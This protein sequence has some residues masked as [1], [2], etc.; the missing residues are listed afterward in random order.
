MKNILQ[1][2]VISIFIL[3]GI[4]IGIWINYPPPAPQNTTVDEF[5]AAAVKEHIQQIAAAPHPIGTAAHAEV[6]DTITNKLA[7]LGLEAEIQNSI[8]IWPPSGNVIRAATVNNIIARLPGSENSRAV[9]LMTHYDSV[10]YAPGANDDSA[11]VAV[12][13]ETMRLITSGQQLNNDIIVLI[14]DGE[15]IGLA[16]AGVFFREHPWAADI[17]VVLNLEARGCSGGVFMFETGPDN[18]WLIKDWKNASKAP[19]G[20]SISNAIYK[21]MPNDTDFSIPKKL[22]LPGLNFAYIDGWF[23]YH[24]PLDNTDHLDLDTLAHYGTNILP[25]VK[26]LGNK[27]LTNLPAGDAVYFQLWPSGMIMYPAAFTWYIIAGI[28][29]LLLITIMVGFHNKRLTAKGLLLGF[30]API[31]YTGVGILLISLL[32]KILRLCL[33][34]SIAEK[35]LYPDYR[36]IFLPAFSLILL[37][38]FFF[39]HRFLSRW[40]NILSLGLGALGW[41]LSGTIALKIL[42]PGG[43]FIFMWPLLFGLLSLWVIFYLDRPESISWSKVFLIGILVLPGLIIF[44]QL[45]F[46]LTLSFRLSSL[47]F[48]IVGIMTGILIPSLAAMSRSAMGRSAAAALVLAAVVFSYGL[49]TQK[50]IV[51]PK[52]ETV[53][54]LLDADT[55]NASLG[56]REKSAWTEKLLTASQ[57]QDLPPYLPLFPGRIFS[58]PAP[59]YPLPAPRIEVVESSE[60]AGNRTAV[61]Q[62][63]SPAQAPVTS[64]FIETENSITQAEISGAGK[65]KSSNDVE[66]PAGIS[67]QRFIFYAIPETGIEL[68]LVFAGTGPI[69]ITAVD[70]SYEPPAGLNLPKPPDQTLL[71]V[72]ST[73][74]KTYQIGE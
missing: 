27:S 47:L 19:F 68:K 66:P 31:F 58:S 60:A 49:I 11:G 37:A 15:E 24:T 4:A 70:I 12:I 40:A 5:S 69:D 61:L 26:V 43:S 28:I 8:A 45:L 57:Q 72:R 65:D 64:L 52:Q 42:L 48:I 21:M 2:L 34:G 14:T 6:R 63:Y 44:G 1:Y 32:L 23:A 46:T 53:F 17:G 55:E 62:V 59:I 13:L 30:L 71:Q 74:K 39:S 7:E 36:N 18:A 50:N 67:P 20:N 73:A 29:G 54:Y 10:P 9:L 56:V 25:A 51:R 16:G 41:W 33:G 35:S 3:G 38:L 22:G